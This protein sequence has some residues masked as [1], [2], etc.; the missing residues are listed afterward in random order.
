METSQIPAG[1]VVVGVDGSS[2]SRHAL[3]WAAAQAQ[4]ENRPLVL[5]HAL[6]V[7]PLVGSAWMDRAGIDHGRLIEEERA[8]GHSVLA[9]AAAQVLA[10][11]PD[12]AVH[13]VLRQ[14]DAREALLGVADDAALLAVGSRGRGPVASLLLGSVSVA[15][16]KH[17][18]CPVVVVRPTDGAERRG[19]VVGT[20]GTERSAPAVE[21]AFRV[22]DAR[23]VPLTV[24]HCFWDAVA[25]VEGTL[26]V[27]DDETDCDD[28]RAMLAQAVAG[29]RERHPDVELRLQLT[30]GFADQRLLEASHDAELVVVGSHPRKVLQQIVY[31]SL[32]PA[33]VEHARCPVAVVPF[34]P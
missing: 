14:V 8:A 12:L 16:S 15:V 2:G 29:H 7:L 5:V 19:V 21:F 33:V 1:A 11:R 9:E 18:P 31:G 34:H 22:A 23:G 3:E 28:M 10:G 32:T 4:L 20:D 30:R 26:D 17:A 27:A 6:G 24:L 25:V 13:Q